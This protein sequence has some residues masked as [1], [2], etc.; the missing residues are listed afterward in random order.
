ME[1]LIVAKPAP[2]DTPLV[3]GVVMPDVVATLSACSNRRPKTNSFTNNKKSMPSKGQAWIFAQSIQSDQAS[4][5][6]FPKP[7]KN[8]EGLNFTHG[9]S[10][11]T[12][13]QGLLNGI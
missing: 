6:G 13:F 1:K 10:G 2:M 4:L 9:A 5:Q 3:Q 7:F 12:T 8:L 11:T